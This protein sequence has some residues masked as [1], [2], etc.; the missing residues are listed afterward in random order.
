MWI[1]WKYIYGWS[2][3]KLQHSV[4]EDCLSSRGTG[5]ETLAFQTL[6]RRGSFLKNAA[7]GEVSFSTPLK[8][9]ELCCGGGGVGSQ[10]EECVGACTV[11]QTVAG[12]W[13]GEGEKKKQ[14]HLLCM[15]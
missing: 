14:Q 5:L 6:V 8:L 2:S 7:A 12:W 10:K 13:G 1:Q 11:N 4:E 3:V 9:E 15:Q